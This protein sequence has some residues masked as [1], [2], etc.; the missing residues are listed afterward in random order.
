MGELGDKLPEEDKTKINSCIEQLRKSLESDDVDAIKSDTEALVQ[1]SHK[2]ADLLYSQQAQQQEPS[3]SDS[4]N[5]EEPPKSDKTA[6]DNDIVDADYEEVD[7]SK[8]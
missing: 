5:A 2:M 3:G 1:A 6:D 4:N 8:K 7:D